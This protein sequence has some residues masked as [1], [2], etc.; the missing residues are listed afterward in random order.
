MNKKVKNFLLIVLLSVGFS[1]VLEAQI[2][3]ETDYTDTANGKQVM[4]YHLNVYNRII[5]INGV[6]SAG[7][8]KNTTFCIVRP[9]EGKTRLS[10]LKLRKVN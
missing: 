3:L 5:P 8:N 2:V 10:C 6:N 4:P 9:L 7:N 1:L